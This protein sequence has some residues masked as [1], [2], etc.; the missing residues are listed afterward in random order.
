MADAP[1]G[2]DQ[3]ED[4]TIQPV[5]G[6]KPKLVRIS[7]PK[8]EENEEPSTQLKPSSNFKLLR[9]TKSKDAKSQAKKRVVNVETST[10]LKPSFNF[11]LLRLTKSKDAK[12]Q[13]KKRVVNVETSTQL[14]PSS[15]FKLLRLTKSKDAKSQA[16]KRVVN[17]LKV[18]ETKP[19]VEKDSNLKDGPDSTKPVSNGKSEVVKADLDEKRIDV[20]EL[21]K[22]M[23]VLKKL[24][25]PTKIVKINPSKSKASGIF[26]L[27]S[28]NFIISFYL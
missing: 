20:K 5:V 17:L 9:L 21:K 15:D 26:Y 7:S 1:E 22:K 12:S 18:T 3:T 2:A 16:K 28:F 13:A 25:L 11:K 24:R 19:T 4:N 27:N 10:Q 14:K 23:A 8:K 6:N